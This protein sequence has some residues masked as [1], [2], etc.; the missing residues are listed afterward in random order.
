MAS[1]F[2]IKSAKNGKHF[3]NLC[4][5]NGEII[6]TSQMYSSK[7]GCRKG[8]ASVR[9]NAGV[10]GRYEHRTGKQGKSHFVLKAANHRVI[11][12]S[13]VYRSKA[14]CE[15]GMKAVMKNGKTKTVISR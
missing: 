5:S 14:A 12:S 13:E 7:S 4:A 2:E 3:F 10:A 9:A 11:G 15:K 1:H 6:L 8:L